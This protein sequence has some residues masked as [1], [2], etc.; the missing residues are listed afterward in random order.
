ML[1]NGEAGAQIN[2]IHQKKKLLYKNKKSAAYS[3][4]ADFSILHMCS[5]IGFLRNGISQWIQTKTY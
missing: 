5:C 2:V 4:A 1:I 3:W